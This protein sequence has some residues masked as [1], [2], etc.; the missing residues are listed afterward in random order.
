[1]KKE[2]VGKYVVAKSKDTRCSWRY[3]P[4]DVN[5]EPDLIKKYLT[6]DQYKLYKLIWERF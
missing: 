3:R 6:S 5:L 1:M 2:Y 4:T